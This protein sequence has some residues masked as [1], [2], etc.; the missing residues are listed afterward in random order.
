MLHTACRLPGRAVCG[1]PVGMKESA[2]ALVLCFMAAFGWSALAAQ[3]KPAAPVSPLAPLASLVGGVWVGAL[4]PPPSGPS[5]SIELRFEWAE[6]KQAIRFDSS[7]VQGEKRKAYTSGMYGWNA[8][9]GKITIYYMDSG[10]NLT[11]GDIT[12]EDGVLVNELLSTD[13]KGQVTPIRVKL[14]KVG[15]NVFTNDIYLQK[16]GAGR[17]SS[18][19]ATS[20]SEG[21]LETTE[22]TEHTE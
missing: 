22:Y 5:M 16:D 15:D 12:L 2:R 19:C 8:A 20:G 21:N 14:T 7:F 1:R 13:P 10:G 11:E 18:T 4:P 17:P 9:K 6:N 3:E